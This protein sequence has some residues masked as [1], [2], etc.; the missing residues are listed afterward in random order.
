MSDPEP[1]PASSPWQK[2]L[3]WAVAAAVW[4]FAVYHFSD[5][6]ADPD[7]WGHVL[8]GQRAW[9]LGWVETA[10]PFSW[11]VPGHPWINH[12]TLAELAMGLAHSLAGGT[13]LL[14]LKMAVGLAAF[15]LALRTGA[16]GLDWPARGAAWSVAA[17]AVVE[18]AWGFAPR[19]QI[20]TALALA[21]QLFLLREVHAGKRGWALALPVLFFLWINTHGGAL[22][23]ILFL[24]LASALGLAEGWVRRDSE[25]R[26]SGGVLGLALV[27]SLLMLLVNPWGWRL[28]VWLVESV[29]YVR[30]EID[31]WNAA[32]LSLAHGPAVLLALLV[33]GTLAATWRRVRWW[34]AGVLLL[35]LYMAARHARHIPLFSLAALALLPRYLAEACARLEEATERLREACAEPRSQA[36]FTAGLAAIG[37]ISLWATVGLRKGSFLSV[38]VEREQYPVQAMRFL[39][40]ARVSGNLVPFFDWAQQAIWELPEMRVSFDGRLDT[41]YPRRVINAH[42]NFY[43]GRPWDGA[44]LDLDRADVVLV[45]RRLACTKLLASRP[46]WHAVY[47]DPLAVAFVRDPA[48]F[49]ALRDRPLPVLRGEE[50]VRG[51][52]PFPGRPSPTVRRE[53][54]RSASR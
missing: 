28:P 36:F 30:P 50:V 40:E 20:F 16:K 33:L 48:R 54:E 32:G 42:W 11:T 27:A 5:N 1:R 38:E 52:E 18:I 41:S 15:G 9:L 14:L 6:K 19:P 22:A 25:L 17:L 45:P 2:P 37:V 12:E 10:D 3:R 7:L 29:L 46:G 21:A 35:L 47:A 13:G 53:L 51:Y 4:L 8:Y 44:S 39:R 23:G 43:S 34:E 24:G 26:K 31:E 49:P